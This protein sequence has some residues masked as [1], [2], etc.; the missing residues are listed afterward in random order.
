MPPGRWGEGKIEAA[1][2]PPAIVKPAAED[3]SAGL[4]RGSVVSDRKSLRA[5]L[6]A[7]TEQFDEVLVQEYIGGREVNVG[8]L[9]DPG[10]PIPGNDL[11][12]LPPGARPL[13]TLHR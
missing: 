11:M 3:A 2:P 13:L 12:R 4:D 7:M 10:L 1:S 9:G 5:R 8:L 6:A